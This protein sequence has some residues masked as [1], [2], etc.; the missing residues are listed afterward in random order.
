MTARGEI[1]FSQDPNNRAAERGR[2]TYD[3]PHR[4]TTNGVVELPFMR[5]QRGSAGRLIGAWQVSGFL[6]FQAGAPFTALNG[7]ETPEGGPRETSWGRR[8]GRI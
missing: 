4:F 6:T 3:R 2:S 1:A 7:T 5:E 8:R